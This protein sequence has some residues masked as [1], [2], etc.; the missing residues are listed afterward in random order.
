[1]EWHQSFI[2]FNLQLSQ[3]SPI[4]YSSPTRM[5]LS[6][7]IYYTTIIC[8]TA[9]N[10]PASLVLLLIGVCY[11][12]LQGQVI[13]T[14]FPLTLS[15]AIN[16]QRSAISNLLVLLNTEI[17]IVP[18]FWWFLDS[19]HVR[20]WVTWPVSMPFVRSS[21]MRIIQYPNS[22]LPQQGLQSLLL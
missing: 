8:T 21:A 12:L 7:F 1:M 9:I 3:H 18:D 5:C 15:I 22:S 2:Y 19:T 17:M 4:Q 10:T 6:F 20:I 13:V 16:A 14:F 11:V